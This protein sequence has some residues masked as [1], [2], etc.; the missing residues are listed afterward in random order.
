MFTYRHSEAPAPGALTALVSAAK[1]QIRL[2]GAGVVA[3]RMPVSVAESLQAEWQRHKH[4][5]SATRVEIV[6]YAVHENTCGLVIAFARCHD[7]TLC[8]GVVVVDENDYEVVCQEGCESK[9]H[10]EA[11]LKKAKIESL[12]RIWCPPPVPVG[13]RHAESIPRL[14]DRC[15]CGSGRKYKKCCGR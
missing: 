8:P 15:S 9:A 1:N 12:D 3:L 2:D 14:N 13:T 10:I 11:K 7:A 4:R 5:A 6:E